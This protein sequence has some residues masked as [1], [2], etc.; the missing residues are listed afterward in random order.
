MTAQVQALLD[1]AKQ[2]SAD[3]RAE[4]IEGLHLLDDGPQLSDA[5]LRQKW[6]PELDRRRELLARGELETIDAR[7][8]IADGRARLRASGK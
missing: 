3:E 1:Q 2:L 6:G 5:E 8:A 4:L 7:E